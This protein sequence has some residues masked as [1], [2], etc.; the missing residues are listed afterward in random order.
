MTS[1]TPMSNLA[2]NNLFNVN[3]IVAVIT[4]GGT[5][6]GLMMARALAANG[7]KRVY[8]LGRRADVL[9]AAVRANPEG[10]IIVA[11]ICDVT[12]KDALQK[13]VDKITNDVGYINLFVANSGVLG[14]ANK[15]D[16]SLPLS[17]VRKNLFTN[18][19]ME[20]MTSALHTNVT[21][22]F[23]SMVAFLELLEA[24]NKNAV[25][26][27]GFGKPV[28]PG[29]NVPSVQSQI[30]V[31]ASIAGFSRKTVSTPAYGSSKAAMIYLTKQ[32]SSALAPYGIR[33]NA[34]APG[35]FPSELAAG[36]IGNRD[37]GTE[38]FESPHFIPVRK[39]G[40]EEEMAGTILYLASRAG[41]FCNG[42]ILVND[43]GRLSVMPSSY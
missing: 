40:G 20:E 34:L 2:V 28:V 8:I 21:G 7:A 43:G 13:C 18:Y 9:S 17:E 10:G 30:I 31:T 15:W 1:G 22:A 42:L 5:G 32:A 41:S 24:G 39:F 33:A 23:F 16:T 25:E 35:L 38:S 11:I 36:L 6:I 4:G 3:G 14:P 29:S 27:G 19:Q 12:D 37:P 26:K